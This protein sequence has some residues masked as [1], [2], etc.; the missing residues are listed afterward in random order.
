LRA[1]AA[2]HVGWG[3]WYLANKEYDQARRS[4]S[5]AAKYHLSRNIATKWALTRLA[6]GLARA[7]SIRRHEREARTG[8]GMARLSAE[9]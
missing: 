1:L 2:V 5:R 3:T 4:I 6:P 9:K 7:L 8:L